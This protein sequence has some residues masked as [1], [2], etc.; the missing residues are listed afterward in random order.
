MSLKKLVPICTMLL[1]AVSAFGQGR[2]TAEVT[3]KGKKVSIDYGKPPL[4]AHGVSELPAGGVWRV[5]M[6]EA[7]RIQTAGDLGINGTTLAAGTYT[8][9]VKRVNDNTWVLAFH[10]KI[11]GANGRNLWGAPPQTSGFVAELP[12]KIETTKDSADPLDITLADS[13]GKAAIKI[14][15]GASVLTGSFDV[16]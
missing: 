8:L 10:P 5:G 3:I 12:L 16:K 13:K 2:G 4:G 11:Q 9:W 14:H 15:W 7:T 6:N 1:L